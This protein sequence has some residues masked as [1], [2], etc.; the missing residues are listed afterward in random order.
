[1]MPDTHSSKFHPAGDPFATHAGLNVSDTPYGSSHQVPQSAYNN[2]QEPGME[3]LPP[4]LPLN[5]GHMQFG[6]PTS[7][8]NAGPQDPQVPNEASL[9]PIIPVWYPADN[10]W[11]ACRQKMAAAKQSIQ[12]EFSGERFEEMR[13]REPTQYEKMQDTLFQETGGKLGKQYKTQ[14]R[15]ASVIDLYQDWR[16]PG[17]NSSWYRGG[18][19]GEESTAEAPAK[20]RRLLEDVMDVPYH[21][22]DGSSGNF[23]PFQ[24]RLY[25]GALEDFYLVAGMQAVAMKPQ[26][27]A[28]VFVNMDYSD[29]KL[30]LFIIRLYKHGQW[31]YVDI[32]DS[33]PYDRNNSPL[34]C[35]SEFFPTCAWAPLV[36]KAYAKL[37][38][39]WEGLGG[40]GH[41]EEVMADLTGGCAS[42]FG[43]TDV[44]QDRLFQYLE[45]MQQWCV[46]GCNINEAECSKRNVPIDAHWACAIFRVTR[47]DGTPYVCV[48]M[49]APTA[50]VMHM[51]VCSVASE[52]GYGISDGFAWLRIDDFVAF[53]DTIYECRLVNS[54]LGPPQMTGIPYS[55]GWIAGSP[56]FEEMW[57][58]QGDVYSETAPSFLIEVPQT[59]NEITLEVSQTDLRY[60][61]PDVEFEGSRALQAPLLLRFYQCSKDVSD[62]GSGEIY[63]VHLSAWGHCRDACTG[64][65]VMKPGRYLAMISVPA[66][67]VCHRMIFRT[68]STMPVAMKPVT[69]HRNWVVVNPAVPLDALPYSLAGYQRVDSYAERLPQMFNEAEGR[70]R[71]RAN[72]EVGRQELTGWQRQVQQQLSRG[73]GMVRGEEV[74]G[75]KIIGKFGGRDAIASTEAREM[76]E[77]CHIM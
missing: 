5:S 55:P 39:S 69:Q 14:M 71:P 38:G 59:P 43:T 4:S 46:F 21:Q 25:Q 32:D 73:A 15:K 31:H 67:Y 63:L 18:Q 10:N 28:N 61:D 66:K 74:D 50:T 76:Q 26:L 30:G 41:V 23:V 48:C 34:C 17:E 62:L 19:P 60:N 68:Y 24:G 51:P 8:P 3:G 36:E 13:V 56:W 22:A 40:G 20:W 65:K 54:D 70:G 9:A 12:E 27:I 16:F 45:V 7:G 11:Q 77:G 52:E 57:A 6:P 64:V 29:P 49:A 75:H 72:S 1:M 58:F 47:Q 37:H 33:L 44:A 42:R 35:S 53:F 2:P